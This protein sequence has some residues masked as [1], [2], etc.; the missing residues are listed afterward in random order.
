MPQKCGQFDLAHKFYINKNPQ[1]NTYCINQ[2]EADTKKQGVF[3]GPWTTVYGYYYSD[4]C[5][6]I[7][8]GGHITI[9]LNELYQTESSLT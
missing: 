8:C 7:F 2:F 1:Y 9:S 5:Q 3:F 4:K 6:T